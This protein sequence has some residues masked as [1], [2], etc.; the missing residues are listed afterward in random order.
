MELLMEDFIFL[1]FLE[2][3]NEDFEVE[4]KIE[5]NINLFIVINFVV[6]VEDFNIV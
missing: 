2:E 1:V 3:L 4:V 6:G 5:G